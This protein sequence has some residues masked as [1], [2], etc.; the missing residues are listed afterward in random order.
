[1]VKYPSKRPNHEQ[2]VPLAPDPLSA[3]PRE[4]MER[5]R[6]MARRYLPNDVLLWAGVA[7][8]SD[9]EAS[10]WVRV[11]C[12]RLLAEVAGAIPQ[13][14]PAAPQPHDEDGDGSSGGPS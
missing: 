5:A 8:G 9:S 2:R 14:V 12:G 4:G 1:M 3:S 13:P 10:L 7:F 11:Q 6:E